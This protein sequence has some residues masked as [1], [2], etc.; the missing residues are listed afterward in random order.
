MRCF[1]SRNQVE[2]EECASFTS[3]VRHKVQGDV[4][5]DGVQDLS[6]G[7]LAYLQVSKGEWR[8]LYGMSVNIEA[9]ASADAW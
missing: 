9:N 2:E 5:D 4:E 3:E 7:R 1:N 6:K 8:T